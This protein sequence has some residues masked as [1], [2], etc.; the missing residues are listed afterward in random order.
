MD[1]LAIEIIG[2]DESS[3]QCL[4]AE[5]LLFYSQASLTDKSG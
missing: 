2:A 1:T 5:T 3:F 4:Y